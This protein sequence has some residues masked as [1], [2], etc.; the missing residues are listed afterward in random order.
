MLLLMTLFTN[1]Q[2]IKSSVIT[3]FG[4]F[5]P[6]DPD[7]LIKQTDTIPMILGNSFGFHFKIIAD[8]DNKSIPLTMKV[9]ITDIQGKV[10]DIQY[11]MNYLPHDF[12]TGRHSYV[13]EAPEE[14]IAG[15]WKFSIEFGGKEILRKNLVVKE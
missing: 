9:T 5:N 2:E 8:P 1:A 11:K 3:D 4:L 10:H 15:D 13:F 7:Q 6:A 14:L 12:T